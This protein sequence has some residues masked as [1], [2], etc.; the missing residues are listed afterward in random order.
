MFFFPI[1]AQGVETTAMTVAMSVLMLA[2]HP[3]AQ[4]RVHAEIAALNCTANKVTDVTHAD[5]AHMPYT[6][7]VLKET[8]RL[9]PPVP[10]M[11]RLITSD[12]RLT[13]CTLP[14]GTI[15][16]IPVYRLQRSAIVW[17]H[18]HD[19][20]V[21]ERFSPERSH[22]FDPFFFMPFSH[23][24]RNCIGSKYAMMSV[25]VFLCHLVTQYEFHTDMKFNELEIRRETTLHLENEYAITA[26]RRL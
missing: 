20:F 10:F 14:Q 17:G 21:P 3:T 16:I 2:M 7:M 12:I 1:F 9:F 22:E 11:S 13:K 4:A 8:M 19:Q 24:P 6:E 25:R 5:T 18:D 26:R 23:G 15:A